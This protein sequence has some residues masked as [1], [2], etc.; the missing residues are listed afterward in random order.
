MNWS[1]YSRLVG[2]VFGG[3]L[4]ME[5]LVAFFWNRPSSA[6]GSSLER[7]SKKATWPPSGWSQRE[8]C[9]PPPHHGG[10][11]V[12]QHPVGYAITTRRS[13]QLTI[14]WA[15]SEPVFVWIYPC[16]LAFPG[17][18]GVLMLAVACWH[19]R[20]QQQVEAFKR[21]AVISLAVCC[22]PSSLPFSWAVSSE[23]W[24]PRTSDEDRGGRGPVDHL[25]QPLLVL[26]V[27]DRRRQQRP[28]AT[29][30][31]LIPDLLSILATNS[32]N[33]KVEGLTS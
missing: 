1:A 6:S 19:L 16:L 9:S 26:G 3:P 15:S 8:R 11:L 29:Q 10:E 13:T 31:I 7:L 14:L 28:H 18:R 12:M 27:P 5:G 24:R 30:I 32:P 22:P 23:W 2:N 20:R 4:A 33:G 21:A 25:R 17:H